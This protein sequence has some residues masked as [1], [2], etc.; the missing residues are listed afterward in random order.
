METD[1]RENGLKKEKE[2]QRKHMTEKTDLSK[3][4]YD[5]GNRR[6]G[7]LTK[8][9]GDTTTVESKDRENG[10]KKVKERTRK[11]KTEK[12]DLRK[13]KNDSGSRK[14]RRKKLRKKKNASGN[15]RRRE[16]TKER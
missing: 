8:E 9:R 13:R 11:E 16:L 14:Q 4:K 10:L 3:R 2:R 1:D 12:M 5:S 7:K 15:R 6:Q